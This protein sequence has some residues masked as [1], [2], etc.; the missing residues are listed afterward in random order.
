LLTPN[1]SEFEAVAG[2]CGNDEQLLARAVEMVDTL[3]L[4]ALLVTRSEK[5]M[6]LVAAEGHEPL[7]LSTLAR[8]VF[9]V[10]G[11]GDTVIA[12]LAVALASGAT[13]VEAA[14]LAN[15]AAGI[16]VGRFGPATVSPAELLAV[17]GA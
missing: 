6:L 4:E 5:G 7:F 12:T 2:P 14:R 13:L 11:A 17:I 15:E 10:T 16:V 1:Q 3:A 9:D 8:E